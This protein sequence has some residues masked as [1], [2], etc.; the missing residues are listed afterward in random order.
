MHINT[1]LLTKLIH[2]GRIEI[3]THGLIVKKK[4]M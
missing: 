1:Y 2:K 4:C 3:Y